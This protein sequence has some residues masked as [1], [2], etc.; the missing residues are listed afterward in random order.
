MEATHERADVVIVGSGYG[1]AIT[2]LRLAEAGVRCV[3]IE[4][5]RR[6]PVTPAGDTFTT[7]VAPDGRAAW[8]DTKSPLSEAVFDKYT[9]ILESFEG[10]G[11]TV[12]AAAGYGGASLTSNGTMI[13]PLPR[14]F[15]DA[16]GDSL[17]YEE[18]HERWYPEARSLIGCSP[19]PDELY[20]SP[21][22]E[23]ARTFADQAA[24][25]GL[26]VEKVPL[27]VDW[28][29]IRDEADGTRVMAELLGLNLFGVNSGAQ[30]SLDRTLL[31]RAEATLRVDVRTLT[32]VTGVHPD[33]AGYRVAYQRIDETGRVLGRGTLT[34]RHLVLSAGSLGT[35]RML[36]RAR[37]TGALPDLDASVGSMIGNSELVT[38]RT[39]MPENNPGQGGP[40]AIL[41]RDTDNPHAPT[42]MLNFP[43][44]DAPPGVGAVAAIG[45]SPSPPAGSYRYDADS[46]EVR[47]TWPVDD[48][49]V[50][51]MTDA[52]HATLDKLNAANPGTRTELTISGASGNTVGGVPL[53]LACDT[54]GRLH[55]YRNLYVVDGS[56]LHGSSAGVPPALTVAA[57]AARCAARIV[58]TIA[59]DT[60]RYGG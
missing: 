60:G 29:A 51:R 27:A 36:V 2:A 22:Y 31:A 46:G 47:M 19:I 54:A 15:R 38:I 35:T 17:D 33:G 48:P 7:Q 18:M 34:A 11:T 57:V 23:S 21:F 6:W 9:G 16:F 52:M 42:A 12:L 58:P 20:A 1:G 25:A 28:D 14:L 45:A 55:G 4:R 50:R 49:R 40:S 53:G 3:L 13:E 32:D 41:V 24:K 26:S 59:A 39:G 44:V 5:G 43:W 8:L 37:G 30:R 56:L 10:E